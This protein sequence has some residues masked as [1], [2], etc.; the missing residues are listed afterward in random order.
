M[1]LQRPMFLQIWLHL[2]LEKTKNQMTDQ[3]HETNHEHRYQII[4]NGP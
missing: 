1:L 3:D 2:P 4:R